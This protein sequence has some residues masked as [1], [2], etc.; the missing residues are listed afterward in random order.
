MIVDAVAPRCWDIPRPVGQLCRGCSPHSGGERRNS[1]FLR[2]H[3]VESLPGTPHSPP[4]T[5]NGD[6][7]QAPSRENTTARERGAA[8]MNTEARRT[9]E[10]TEELHRRSSVSS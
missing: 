7:A 10:D 2:V 9:T 8:V 6:D 3:C 1:A 5:G 4:Q